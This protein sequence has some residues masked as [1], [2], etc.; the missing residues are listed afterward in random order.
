MRLEHF[1]YLKKR[2]S[3]VFDRTYFSADVGLLR[4][5]KN[6]YNT[7]QESKGNV[8]LII[9]LYLCHMSYVLLKCDFAGDLTLTCPRCFGPTP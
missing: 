6:Y 3:V 2:H 9:I 7:E 8:I 1:I 4:G 5:V